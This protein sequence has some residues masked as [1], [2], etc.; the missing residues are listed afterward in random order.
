MSKSATSTEADEIDLG[1]NSRAVGVR[2][3]QLVADLL[4]RQAGGQQS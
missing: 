2:V 4:E 1:I 3:P